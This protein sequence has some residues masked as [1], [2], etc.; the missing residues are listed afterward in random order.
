MANYDFV[1]YHQPG[2]RSVVADFLSRP[3]EEDEGQDNN[4]GVVLLPEAH[5]AKMSFPIELKEQRAILA[6]YHDHPTAGHP[7]IECTRKL[8]G[9]RYEGGNLDD[10]VEGYV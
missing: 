2:K 10:F 7:G 5:F 8:V 6:R 3:F 9:Q 1:L 4:K